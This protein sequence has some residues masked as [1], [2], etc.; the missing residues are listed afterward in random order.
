MQQH[1]MWHQKHPNEDYQTCNICQQCGKVCTD[2]NA[3]K[4]HVRQVHCD[5][6]LKCTHAN[7]RK[8]FK[9]Q[10]ALKSHL[11][12]HEGIKNFVCSECGFA[13]RSKQEMKGHM[14]RKHSHVKRSIP[15][16]ICG[17]LFR[18][19]SNLKSHF[20]IHKQQSERQHRCKGQLI[21]NCLNEIIVWTKISTKNLTNPALEWVGQNLSNFSLVFWSKR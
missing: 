6:T 7:C 17:K 10:V 9:T 2:Y 14:L 3:M 11:D 20:N 21:S 12:I 4:F 15:C 5:R 16:E 1:V 18:H 8:V 13:F 19:M